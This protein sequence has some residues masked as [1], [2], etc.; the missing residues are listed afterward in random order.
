MHIMHKSIRFVVVVALLASLELNVCYGSGQ[1]IQRV[2][3]HQPKYDN[4]VSFY[5]YFCNRPISIIDYSL[6]FIYKIPV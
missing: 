2:Y 4:K 1:I 3:Y 5:L 6:K